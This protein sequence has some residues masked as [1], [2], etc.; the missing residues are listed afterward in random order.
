MINISYVDKIYN[1]NFYGLKGFFSYT[2]CGDDFETCQC[3]G[4][5]DFL[6]SK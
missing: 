6:K 1:Y 5:F 2:P 4:K 3:C